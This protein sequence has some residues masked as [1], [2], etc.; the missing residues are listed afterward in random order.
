MFYHK[1]RYDNTPDWYKVIEIQNGY[2]LICNAFK[3]D[4]ADIG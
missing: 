3:H 2:F 1:M 4:F